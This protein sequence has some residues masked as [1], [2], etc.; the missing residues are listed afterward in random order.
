MPGESDYNDST[1]PDYAYDPDDGDF[2]AELADGHFVSGE[3]GAVTVA[4]T[5]DAL[6]SPTASQSSQQHTP[7]ASPTTQ[8]PTQYKPW[9]MIK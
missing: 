5:Y 1:G 9:E 2:E 7:H 3:N 4:P 6:P 8:S